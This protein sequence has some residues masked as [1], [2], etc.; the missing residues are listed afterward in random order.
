M[1]SLKPILLPSTDLKTLP[2]LLSEFL[3]L[4]LTDEVCNFPLT[5]CKFK[6]HI[7]RVDA[8]GTACRRGAPQRFLKHSMLH[9]PEG[10]VL[11]LVGTA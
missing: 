2:L 1:F 3:N 8:S 6:L 5:N 10:K 9:V 11:R 4:D 7:L